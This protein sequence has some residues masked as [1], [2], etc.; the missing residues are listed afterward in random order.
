MEA[1]L[2]QYE[3][4][5]AYQVAGVTTAATFRTADIYLQMGQALLDSER[6]TGLSGEALVEYDLLLEEQA[7]PFE[8]QAIALH[9]TNVGRMQ[10]GLFDEWT[11]QSLAA[12]AELVPARYAR[13]ERSVAYVERMH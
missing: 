5:A 6:P 8:E 12:L 11:E 7:Y 1:A 4:A 2:R 13:Q 3:L 10:E 9:E